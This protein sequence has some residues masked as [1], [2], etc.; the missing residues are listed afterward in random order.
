VSFAPSTKAS[1]ILRADGILRQ[2][3]L[4]F[5]G[6]MALN[7]GSFAFHALSSRMLGV[8]AYGTLYALI[9]LVTLLLMPGALLSPVVSRFAA[10]FAT[11]RD[12]GHMRGLL[13][14]VARFCGVAAL[15][16]VGAALLFAA[17]AAAYFG[18]PAWGIP[19]AAVIA[20]CGFGSGVLRSV[21]QGIQDFRA[22]ALSTAAEG[23]MRVGALLALSLFG[24]RVFTALLGLFAGML[25]GLL[26]A[27]RHLIARFDGGVTST[28]RY[29]W[30]RIAQ[31]TAGACAIILA[32]T[33][34]GS[35]D[36][37]VVKRFFSS[38]DAG[39]YSAAALAGKAVLYLVSFIPA[40]MLPRVTEGH[41]RG[42][43]VR[44][45]FWESLGLLLVLGVCAFLALSLYAR[46]FLHAL[47]GGAFDG[48]L[49]LVMPYAGA[50]TLL[51][52]TTLLAS[53]GVA[54]H[55]LAFAGPLVAG[56]VATLLAIDVYH[57][58]LIA[59]ATEMLAGNALTCA[60]VIFVLGLR[61]TLRAAE[62]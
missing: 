9:A 61:H 30:R 17:P 35:V 7:L 10:E 29:D 60:L 43:R 53:Y 24:L 56:T 19:A 28:V 41:V 59:V 38:S 32:T 50:M 12:D 51:A 58:S 46:T 3:A 36:V 34:M 26:V 42:E 8:A 40:V 11:L 18:V 31:S 25:G 1:E 45:A 57:P 5:L 62:Q 33:C 37:V 21:C 47:V 15:A 4:A 44:T 13:A 14:D 16:Y 6:S 49:P 52:V 55:R 39:L 54:T 22:Y 27:A 48:A 23:A 2:G 20:A